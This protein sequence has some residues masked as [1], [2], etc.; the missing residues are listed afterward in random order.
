MI[1]SDQKENEKNWN[2]ETS[3]K[4]YDFLWFDKKKI[5]VL[6]IIF[7]LFYIPHI[8]QHA[9]NVRKN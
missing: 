6:V 1:T 3:K 5:E 8:N 7:F 4:I 9:G 2:S